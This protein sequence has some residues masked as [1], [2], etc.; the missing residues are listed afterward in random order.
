MIKY[1]AMLVKFGVDISRLE[2]NT[3]RSLGTV[4]LFFTNHS[5]GPVVI[6]ATYDGNHSAGSLHYANCAYDIWYPISQEWTE[7]YQSGFVELFKQYHGQD[8]DIVFEP[9]HIHIEY[10][11]K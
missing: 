1:Q 8:F 2:R 7:F 10:D 9:G 6:S 4:K 11:P 3:R 5:L